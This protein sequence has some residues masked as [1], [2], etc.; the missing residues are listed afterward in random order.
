[1]VLPC[2]VCVTDV[3]VSGYI[4]GEYGDGCLNVRNE[5]DIC[6]VFVF[7]AVNENSPGS[8]KLAYNSY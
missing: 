4:Q 8:S 2:Q 3:N 5:I 6:G 7:W 1:M